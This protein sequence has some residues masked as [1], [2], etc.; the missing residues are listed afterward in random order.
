MNTPQSLSSAIDTFTTTVGAAWPGERAVFRGRDM[1]TDINNPDRIDLP[2]WLEI[3]AFGIMGVHITKAQLRLMEYM[4]VG[5][6]YADAR[7]WNNRVVAICASARSTPALALSA[8]QAVSEALIY[9]R[10]NEAKAVSFFRRAVE[11]QNAGMSLAEII[12]FQVK[13]QG[14]L[15]GYGRPI[16]SEEDERIGPTMTIA[17]QVGLANEPHISIAFDIEQHLAEI[18]KPLKMNLGAL[19]SAIG[20]DMGFTAREF[21]LFLFAAFSSGM[22]PVYLE[23]ADKPA[24]SVFPIPC[25]GVVYEGVPVRSVSKS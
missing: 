10:R 8:G 24:L 6:S 16:S 4:W 20:A 21:N 23:A 22:Q 18:G 13:T 17:R 12:E 1:H 25:S 5:T 2:T 11:Q 3:C 19:V 7:I 14:K 15:P 9:G